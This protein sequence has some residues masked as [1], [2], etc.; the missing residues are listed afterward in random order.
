M[1]YIYCHG[2]LVIISHFLQ[3][4]KVYRF[5]YSKKSGGT[6]QVVIN[7]KRNYTE[8]WADGITVYNYFDKVRHSERPCRCHGVILLVVHVWAVDTFFI[9]FR[10]MMWS[11]QRCLSSN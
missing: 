7:K 10:H 6:D 11:L 1:Y 9:S 3:E 2:L 5:E 4:E 8:M